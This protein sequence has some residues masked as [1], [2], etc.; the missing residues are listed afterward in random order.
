MAVKI[1]DQ[2]NLVPPLDLLYL[3]F[4]CDYFWVFHRIRVEPAPVKVETGKIA[5][6]IS[7]GNSI[8]V[9]HWNDEDVKSP[10][11]EIYLARVPQQF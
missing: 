9:D 5:A 7:E 4:D 2:F 8:H 11:Q 3:I 1:E 6:I 10:V